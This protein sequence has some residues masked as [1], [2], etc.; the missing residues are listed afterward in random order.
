MGGVRLLHKLTEQELMHYHVED[1]GNPICGQKV[2]CGNSIKDDS[3]S[4]KI[5]DLAM[6]KLMNAS[7][8]TSLVC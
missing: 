7:R 5:L 3:N 2:V 1:Q 4:W 6:K 8:P